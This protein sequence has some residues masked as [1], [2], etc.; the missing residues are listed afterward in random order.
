MSAGDAPPVSSTR[1]RPATAMEILIQ[2]SRTQQSER[3]SRTDIQTR[4]MCWS[5]TC[6]TRMCQDMLDARPGSVSICALLA[7]RGWRPGL[8]LVGRRSSVVGR[9]S[10]VVG[11]SWRCWAVLWC[12]VLVELTMR[13]AVPG[14]VGGSGAGPLRSGTGPGTPSVRPEPRWEPARRPSGRSKGIE[15]SSS[16]MSHAR[17]TCSKRS[18]SRRC[19]PSSDPH[20]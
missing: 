19:H 3:T 10:S 8:A 18:S 17:V 11:R 6:L 5:G 7:S 1:G 4:L 13:A 16:R 2:N 20:P 12:R 14:R 15:F 9:R